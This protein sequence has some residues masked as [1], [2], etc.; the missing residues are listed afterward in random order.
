MRQANITTCTTVA[1]S[2]SDFE[3]EDYVPS[4]R[5]SVASVTYSHCMATLLQQVQPLSFEAVEIQAE[6]YLP[7]KFPLDMGAAAA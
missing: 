3:D 2:D 6:V 4:E 7:P 5:C 1:I